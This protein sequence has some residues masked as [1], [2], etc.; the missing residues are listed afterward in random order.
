LEAGIAQ[1]TVFMTWLASP[2]D[3]GRIQVVTA[4]ILTY[5]TPV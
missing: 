1:A 3:V 2:V 4:T 5:T